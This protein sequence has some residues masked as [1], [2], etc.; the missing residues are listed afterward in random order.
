MDKK[1]PLALKWLSASRLVENVKNVASFT[2]CI[3]IWKTSIKQM[4][5]IAYKPYQLV[6]LN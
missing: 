2:K 4:F 1:N 3:N 5:L 6:C